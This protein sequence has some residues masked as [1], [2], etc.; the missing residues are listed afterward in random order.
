MN[1]PAHRKTGRFAVSTICGQPIEWWWVRGLQDQGDTGGRWIPEQNRIELDRDLSPLE[2]Q[3]HA[4]HEA[5]HAAETFGG[6]KIR[7][8]KVR[9]LGLFLREAV[10]PI[11]TQRRVP[12][13]GKRA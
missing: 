1:D 12:S 2:A 9:L 10:G 6:F 4:L 11:L 7:H 13:R 5:I 3:E 8:R